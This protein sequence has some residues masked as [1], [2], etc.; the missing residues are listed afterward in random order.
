ML[1][2]LKGVYYILM[3][4]SSAE[5]AADVCKACGVDLEAIRSYKRANKI[6]QARRLL[7]QRLKAYTN[8]S[9][10]EIAAFIN[11][12]PRYVRYTLSE[13]V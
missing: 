8:L 1:G 10:D 9:V 4:H 13:E 11:R 7:V 3:G 2:R 5:V 6:H 12:S